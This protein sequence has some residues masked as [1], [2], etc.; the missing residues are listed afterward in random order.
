MGG[1]KRMNGGMQKDCLLQ[2]MAVDIVRQKK[3]PKCGFK[4]Q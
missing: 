4:K 1:A 2:R 3:K